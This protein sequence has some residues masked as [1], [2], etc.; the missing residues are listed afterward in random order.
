MHLVEQ[1]QKLDRLLSDLLDLDRLRHGFV[2]PKFRRTDIGLLV[3]KV[4]SEH[5]SKTHPID[6]QTKPVLAEVDA[7]KVERIVENLIANAIKHTPAGT[8]ICV[9]VE[10]HDGGALIAVDDRGPGVVENHRES[11]FEIFNRGNSSVA[12]APGAGVGLSLVT[13]FAALHG[14]RVWFE[15]NPGGGACFRVTLPG[16]R[17]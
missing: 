10:E 11:I 17:I 15:E 2:R 3:S 14:G 16:R 13:Q 8:E 5:P 4:A 6:V 1:A 12:E 7:A 9:R